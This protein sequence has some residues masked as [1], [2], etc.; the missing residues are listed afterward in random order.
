MVRVTR[1]R[2]TKQTKRKRIHIGFNELEAIY[3]RKIRQW[4]LAALAELEPDIAR[5]ALIISML[6]YINPDP[7]EK[8]R[9]KAAVDECRS[10]AQAWGL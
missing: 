3:G 2:V 10:I 1:S 7:E 5:K 4:E 6:C 9:I 8:I